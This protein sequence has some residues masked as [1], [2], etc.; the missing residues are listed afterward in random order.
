MSDVTVLTEL[1]RSKC[2]GGHMVRY[3][4]VSL[5]AQCTMKFHIFFPP[6]ALANEKCA[7]VYFLSG[8]TC[9]DENF[10]QKSGFQRYAAQHSLIVVAPDTSPRGLGYPGETDS[11]DFGVGAGFYVDATQQPWSNGY[12]MFSYITSELPSIISANFGSTS[13]DVSRS[14]IFGHSMGGHGALICALK[15]NGAYKSVSA[16]A[17]ISNPVNCAW[18]KKAFTN[19]LGSDES[20][21]KAYDAT[22]LLKGYAGPALPMLIDVGTSDKFLVEKQLLPDH[23]QAA[24]TLRKADANYHIELEMRYQDGYDHGYFFISTFVEDHLAHHARILNA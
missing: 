15:S 16:F 19:Y 22:E 6:K 5:V 11:W 4:H 3:S 2:F 1:S 24:H 12:R 18:G 14:G 17:P 21:W 9:T 20:T 23:L 7:V 13:A 10:V 8:L